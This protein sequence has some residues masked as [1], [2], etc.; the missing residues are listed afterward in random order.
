MA[1]QFK[2]LDSAKVPPIIKPVV[3]LHDTL[4]KGHREGKDLRSDKLIVNLEKRIEAS[5][6]ALVDL[7]DKHQA[8][9]IELVNALHKIRKALD[10]KKI[11]D[12][13]TS[14]GDY[15]D[16]ACTRLEKKFDIE[17]KQ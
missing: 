8:T 11:K 5:V 2:Y 4:V 7:E 3:Q 10:M 14:L 17:T 12:I 13:R 9:S 6:I 16:D 1:Q 15:M